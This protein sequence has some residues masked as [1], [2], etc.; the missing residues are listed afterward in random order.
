M[1]DMMCV[2]VQDHLNSLRFT[3]TSSVQEDMK[4][5]ENF[6][7]DARNSKT[8]LPNLYHLQSGG[9]SGACVGAIQDKLESMAGE[10]ASV[11]EEQLQ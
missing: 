3:E 2:K 10:V 9:S 1:M 7:K 4:V 8:L 11:M 6:M 5:A